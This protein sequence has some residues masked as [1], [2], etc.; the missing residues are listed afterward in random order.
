MESP[1]LEL[2]PEKS[3]CSTP[4]SKAHD[5]KPYLNSVALKTYVNRLLRGR[6]K[7]KA[8][9]S[10]LHG[11][12]L[13]QWQCEHKHRGSLTAKG[14]CSNDAHES[15]PMFFSVVFEFIGGAPQHLVADGLF[16]WP[17]KFAGPTFHWEQSN[18][19]RLNWG[20]VAFVFFQTPCGSS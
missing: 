10:L 3:S 20:C 9:E 16:K 5:P 1:M 12:S 11:K 4:E 6:L 15:Q 13:K 14:I 2:K 18:A 17:S 8:C 19:A 7:D